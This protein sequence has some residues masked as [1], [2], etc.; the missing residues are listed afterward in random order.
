MEY[1][2]NRHNKIQTILKNIKSKSED[3]F[4]SVLLLLARF[5]QSEKLAALIKRYTEKKTQQLQQEIIRLKWDKFTL[6][7]AAAAI[8]EKEQ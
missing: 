2:I 4:L 3:I 1:T 5:S 8:H 7:K 6:D